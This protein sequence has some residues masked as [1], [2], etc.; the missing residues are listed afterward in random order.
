MT[1]QIRALKHKNALIQL[2]IQPSWIPSKAEAEEALSSEP[3]LTRSHCFYPSS[4]VEQIDYTQISS[5]LSGSAYSS[6]SLMPA[7][8]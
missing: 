7:P 2:C 8:L 3:E 4:T 5:F 6:S 1:Y